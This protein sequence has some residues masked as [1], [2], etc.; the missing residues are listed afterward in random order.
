M[1]GWMDGWVGGWMDGW[2]DGRTDG[3][4]DGRMDGW[5]D[6]WIDALVIR[7]SIR[8][9]GTGALYKAVHSLCDAFLTQKRRQ[10]RQLV[11]YNIIVS[12]CNCFEEGLREIC[13]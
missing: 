12:C 7:N 8:A 3:R 4:T 9:S 6:G 13:H 2:I 10:R 1:D 11:G 5:M